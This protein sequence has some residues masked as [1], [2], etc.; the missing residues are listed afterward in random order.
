MSVEE[1][2]ARMLK[3]FREFAMKGNVVDLAVGV[4]IGAAFGGIV[5][6]LVGDVIMPIVGAVT[7]GLDFSNYF[8]PLS[9]A[10][11]AT[12]LADAKK[13]GA[14]L[15]YGS[16]LTL[17]INFIIVAFVLFLVIRAMN[18]LKRKEEAAPAAPPKPSAEVELLTE[19]RDL[20]KK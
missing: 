1:K 17:T 3:E 12:N 6:S 19:I 14:V 8:I 15:A 2:G 13:Q 10:V 4:I 20:L 18:T 11:T 9:K 16:F 5:T 7:G